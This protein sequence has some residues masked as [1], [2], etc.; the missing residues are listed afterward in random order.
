MSTADVQYCKT[1]VVVNPHKDY[2]GLLQ[3]VRSRLEQ[4]GAEVEVHYV[5]FQEQGMIAPDA[6]ASPPESVSGADLVISLGGDGTLLYTARLFYGQGI[7]VVAVN[8]GTFGFLTEIS[9]EEVFAI[10]DALCRGEASIEKRA[11]LEVWVE[12]S[13]EKLGPFHPMN[14]VVVNRREVSRL[15]TTEVSVNGSYLCTYKADGLIVSTSTGS[16]GYS[17]SAQGPIMMPQLDNLILNPICPHSLASRPFILSG[18]DRV[19][20]RV[21]GHDICPHLSIDVQEGLELKLDDLVHVRRAPSF[22]NLVQSGERTFFQV[23]REKLRW[24]DS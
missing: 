1:A 22:L 6:L 23:L 16:T 14:E 5:P 17:L 20:V 10:L 12:R 7:P 19:S 18:T 2:Q 8:L 3:G 4:M 15:V 21:C 24:V 11:M 9:R 13:G